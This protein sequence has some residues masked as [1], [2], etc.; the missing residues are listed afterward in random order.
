[1]VMGGNPLQ[2]PFLDFLE[3]GPGGPEA[4]F[5]SFQDQFGGSPAQQ[6]FFSGQ[7]PQIQQ[8]FLGQLGQQIRQ[9]GQPSGTFVNFLENFPFTQRFAGLTPFERGGA[10]RSQ[11]APRTRSLFN[12]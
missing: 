1:M 10:R 2:N 9:G 3:E 5:F 12:F 7:F 6:R 11:F 8:E 4:A